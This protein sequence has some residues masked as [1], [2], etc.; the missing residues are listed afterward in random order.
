MLKDTGVYTSKCPK[1]GRSILMHLSSDGSVSP[2]KCPECH[3]EFEGIDNGEH[4]N[5]FVVVVKKEKSRIFVNKEVEE[6]P[7][8]SKER[9]V[10]V[11]SQKDSFKIWRD[12]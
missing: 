3:I 7:K 9:K 12:N 11:K 1:C 10:P 5:T 6:K 8:E 4:R 2:K